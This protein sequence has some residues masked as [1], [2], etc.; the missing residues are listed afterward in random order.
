MMSLT[1]QLL[2]I[3]LRSRFDVIPSIYRFRKIFHQLSFSRHRRR[4]SLSDFVLLFESTIRRF[5]EKDIPLL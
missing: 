2:T 3:S 1:I 5:E 4:F